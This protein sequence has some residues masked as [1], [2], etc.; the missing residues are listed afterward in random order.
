[1][2]IAINVVDDHHINFTHLLTQQANRRRST[3]HG[4]P[5]M[6]STASANMHRP[7]LISLPTTASSP[8]LSDI[9]KEQSHAS[10]KSQPPPSISHQSMEE[11][12]EEEFAL[13][14][15]PCLPAIR[16]VPPDIELA[17]A[18]G[19]LG[20]AKFVFKWIFFVLSF[21]FEIVF[22]W[23][24]PNCSVN[25]KWYVVTVSFIM[26]IVWIAVI[27]FAMVTVVARVGCILNIDEFT[28]GLVVVA[29]GTSVPV[30]SRL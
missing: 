18:G 5:A 29:I 19:N 24:I 3:S 16:A 28:M 1:M 21:P 10:A 30:S 2:Q 13:V 11:E 7:H 9:A 17:R 25:R 23:S 6:G 15:I 22:S 26:S 4:I 12:E 8:Q 20:W 27:S 14:L